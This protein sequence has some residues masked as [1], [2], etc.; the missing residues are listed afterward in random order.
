MRSSACWS[1]G[2]PAL[3]RALAEGVPYVILD[4]K[5][6]DSDRCHEKTL[7]R[8]GGKSTCGTREEEGLG[9]NI[10]ALFYPDGKPY[11]L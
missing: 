9:G 7:S 4:G 3:E 2:R 5:I 1:N 6:V 11:A 8:K 10:Q